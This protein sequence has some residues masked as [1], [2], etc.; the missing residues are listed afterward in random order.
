MIRLLRFGTPTQSP[1]LFAIPGLDGSIGSIQPV[2]EALAKQR[3]VIVADFS[4]ETSSTLE[5][6]ATEIAK[7]I[8]TEGRDTIDVMGQSIG[9]I[10]AAQ[11]ASLHGLPVRKIVLTCTFTI[12][13]W[14]LLRIVVALS[15][16][17]PAWLYRLT[18]WLSLAISCGPVGNGGHHPA[19]AAA[20]DANKNAIAK[21][22]AWQINRDFSHDLVRIRVPLL[23]LMGG[24]DRFVPDAKKEITKL[25]RMFEPQ[26][27]ASIDVIPKAGHIF[28][29]SAAVALAVAEIEEFLR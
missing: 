14:N 1:P 20:R 9:T 3:E 23:I 4:T 22:T 5:A 18:S 25:R 6:L 7:V 27:A 2:V 29:P 28:L 26:P 10:L 24:N 17:A 8:K 16:L 15:K 11:V 19:F 12:C 13:R 21:R